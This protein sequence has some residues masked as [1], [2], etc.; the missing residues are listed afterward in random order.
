[1][2]GGS[3]FV[4]AA[5]RSRAF[6]PAAGVIVLTAGKDLMLGSKAVA[7]HPA[8]PGRRRVVCEPTSLRLCTAGRGRT[9][10][11]TLSDH[12]PRPGRPAPSPIKTAARLIDALAAED[13]RR[14]HW[15]R[16][17]ERGRSEGRHPTQPIGGR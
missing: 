7:G 3:L 16:F 12:G 6:D 13:S 17:S 9:W 2:K 14:P 1:M 4:C 11:I 10:R 15:G 8:R 5:H